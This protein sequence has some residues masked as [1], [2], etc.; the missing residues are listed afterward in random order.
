MLKISV[1]VL[2]Y[3]CLLK[4]NSPVEK[5]ESKVLLSIF[6][7]VQKTRLTGYTFKNRNATKDSFEAINITNAATTMYVF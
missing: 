1:F 4:I 7:V 3:K 5:F 2:F 6:L